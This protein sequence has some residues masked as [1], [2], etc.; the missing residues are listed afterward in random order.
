MPLERVR[1]ISIRVGENEVL[2]SPTMICKGYMEPEDIC[3]VDLEG[4][5]IEGFSRADCALITTDSVRHVVT[6]KENPDCHLLQGRPIRLRFHL[7]N[8]KLY[9]FQFKDS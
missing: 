4:N 3:A 1:P 9:A 5:V 7:K 6:W 8:A 2:C